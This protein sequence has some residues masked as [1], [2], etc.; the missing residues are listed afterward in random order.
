MQASEQLEVDVLEVHVVDELARLA[1]QRE[2]IAAAERAVAR[3][4]AEPEQRGVHALEQRVHLARRL[5]V[6]AG[7]RVERRREAALAAALGRAVDVVDQQALPPR[8]P[9]HASRCASIAP[10]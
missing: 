4:E 7:V 3:V 10:A 2:R 8:S 5:D 9:S 1:Q 6:A